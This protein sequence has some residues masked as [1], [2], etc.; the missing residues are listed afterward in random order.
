MKVLA[1]RL[2]AATWILLAMVAGAAPSKDAKNPAPFLRGTNAG[3]VDNKTGD[4]YYY[5]YAGPGK[6]DVA[7]TFQ[8][9]GI[10]GNPMR[11]YLDIDFWD[12]V[13]KL[14][15]HNRLVSQSGVERVAFAMEFDQR[16]RI[17]V[18][19]I[20]Q[21]GLVRLGGR[22]EITLAGAA[23]F[24]AEGEARPEEA[25]PPSDNA[26][27]HPVGPLYKPV[28]P[29]VKN[30]GP[31]YKPVGALYKPVGSLTVSETAEEIRLTLEA[32][33]LFD[34]DKATIRPDAAEA[35]SRAADVIRE[36]AKGEVRVEGHTD[37]KGA[38]DYN[39]RLSQQRAAAVEAW[40]V[41]RA[42]LPADKFRTA[43][44]GETRPV[45]SNTKPDGSDD[46]AGRQRNRRVE[47]LIRK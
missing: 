8:S 45:A 33:V 9:I 7:L 28:G 30:V 4:H 31:L 37:S 36:R 12:D 40:L 42:E 29:L 5:F 44:Y 25:P 14:R 17:R 35:L 20:P 41:Q 21:E 43:A 23:A 13:P 18:A 34:F 2:L 6:V 15:S 10:F 32:D 16:E 3:N 1:T 22:Y 46:P 39:L 19:V 38:D 26:L 47:L 11:Q 24:D 27:Y